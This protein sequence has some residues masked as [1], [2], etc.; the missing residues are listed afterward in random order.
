MVEILE[1]GD[2][3][4][5][6]DV[7]LSLESAVSVDEAGGGV[8]SARRRTMSMDPIS[9][10][11]SSRPRLPSLT[12][13]NSFSEVIAPMFREIELAVGVVEGSAADSSG[14]SG[15]EAGEDSSRA[16]FYIADDEIKPGKS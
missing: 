11:S 7:R 16:D 8:Q 6:G 14:G 5:G 3:V 10:N 12:R 1:G 4:V 2:S 9:S 13:Q 15:V